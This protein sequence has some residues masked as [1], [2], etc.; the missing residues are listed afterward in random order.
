MVALGSIFIEMIRKKTESLRAVQNSVEEGL[1]QVRTLLVDWGHSGKATMLFVPR[2]VCEALLA[3]PFT[4][5]SR[6][7]NWHAEKHRKASRH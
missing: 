3:N 5:C 4:S 6:Y 1:D 2:S 7:T